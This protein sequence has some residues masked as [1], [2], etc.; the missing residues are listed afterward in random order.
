MA[1]GPTYVVMTVAQAKEIGQWLPIEE[2]VLFL[3]APEP[4]DVRAITDP[5][6]VFGTRPLEDAPVFY[7]V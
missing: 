6:A 5:I 2:L 7:P 4:C 3:S 1:S